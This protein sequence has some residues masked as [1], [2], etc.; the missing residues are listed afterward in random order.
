ME[1]IPVCLSAMSLGGR[2]G[3]PPKYHLIDHELPVIF[4]NGPL[5]LFEFRIR[6]IGTFRPFPSMSPLYP[7][8]SHLPFHFGGQSFAF[9]RRIGRRLI[10]T[11]MAN[12][13]FGT[14]FLDTLHTIFHPMPIRRMPIQGRLDLVLVHPIPPRCMPKP[15]IGIP[16]IINKFQI[17][18]FAAWLWS[19]L[20]GIQVHQ[21]SS[22]F[23]V[24]TKTIA[25][26]PYPKGA[27]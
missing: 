10:I 5:C 26:L 13:F 24:K 27:F 18:S 14:N 8:G 15:E 2:N 1:E 11:D 25:F 17:L 16:T 20:E 3:R 19:N 12:C 6:E 22:L 23:I 7:I 21:M 4:P 9:P